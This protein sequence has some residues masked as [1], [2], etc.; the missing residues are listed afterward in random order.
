MRISNAKNQLPAVIVSGCLMGTACRYD[1][2]TFYVSRMPEL[3][4]CCCPIA[5]CPE[6]LVGQKIPRDAVEQVRER[7]ITINGVDQTSCFQDGAQKVLKIAQDFGAVYAL[8]KSGS[9]SCGSD[10]VYDGTFSNHL[11]PGMGF[12]ARLL[13]DN[14]IKVFSENNMSELIPL[15][16][17]KKVKK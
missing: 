17:K 1:G 12:T 5:V 13:H 16:K 7:A 10:L 15:L 9:P 8:L 2:S 11:I 3:L 4:S 14:G 6:L